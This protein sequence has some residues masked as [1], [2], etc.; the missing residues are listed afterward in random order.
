[1]LMLPN[2]IASSYYCYLNL[3]KDYFF[4]AHNGLNIEG[5]ITLKSRK[6]YDMELF[7]FHINSF[8]HEDYTRESG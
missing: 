1:M 3:V 5:T 4:I 7:F 8:N 2:T 6:C